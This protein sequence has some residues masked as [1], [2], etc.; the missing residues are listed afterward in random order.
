MTA[1]QAMAYGR[2]V[3]ATRVGGL[4]DLDAGAVLVPVGDASGLRAAVL[5][6]LDDAAARRE[7]GE[8]G[9]AVA[10]S[11]FSIAASSEALVAAYRASVS[12]T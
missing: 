5:R 3:V 9:R 2:P 4:A 6:L 8:R 11:S 12:S 7:V 10:K 1:R